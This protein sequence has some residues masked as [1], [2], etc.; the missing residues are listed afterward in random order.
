MRRMVVGAA[1]SAVVV[2]APSTAL[3]RSASPASQGRKE[4]ASAELT[5]LR[6]PS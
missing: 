4:E 5:P 6:W 3:R 1:E 2:F